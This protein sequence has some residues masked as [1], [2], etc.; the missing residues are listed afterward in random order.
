MKELDLLF[1]TVIDGM[2]GMAKGIETLADKL[3]TLSKSRFDE[4]YKGKAKPKSKAPT[5]AVKKKSVKKAPA[6]KTAGKKAATAADTVFEIINKS[7]KGVNTATLMEKT[8]FDR[9]KISNVIYKLKN[10]G[11]IKSAGKG[12]YLK[13]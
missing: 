9:K 3:D 10:Q 6:K 12:I 1:K 2:R 5:K 7:K 8:G 13:V 11:K 4:I